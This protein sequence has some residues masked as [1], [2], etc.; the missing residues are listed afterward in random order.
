M[1]K[2]TIAE[3]VEVIPVSESTLRRDLESGKIAFETD[4]EGQKQINASE[5]NRVYGP[6]KQRNG[7]KP[8][9][10]LPSEDAAL[11]NPVINPHNN[12]KT[13]AL[14]KN[15]VADLEMQLAQASDREVML[16]YEKSK[17]LDS[18]TAEREKTRL[19]MMLNQRKN[20]HKKPNWFC[21]LVGT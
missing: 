21:R 4:P 10:Q 5:L 16:M 18:L 14:L 15:Q 1:S 9:L 8:V 6:L 11:Q 12:E 20:R 2:L 13:I 19:L 7:T 17:L 3:A